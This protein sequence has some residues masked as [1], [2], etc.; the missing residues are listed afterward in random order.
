[1]K[2]ITRPI[3]A[4]LALSLLA[5]MPRATAADL[6]TITSREGGEAGLVVLVEPADVTLA[7]E[8]A[9]AGRHLVVALSADAARVAQ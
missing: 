2:K 3:A 7:T 8:L 4:M 9:A 6:Q 5:V 1:M